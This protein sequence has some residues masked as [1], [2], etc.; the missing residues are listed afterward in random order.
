LSK[1]SSA[2]LIIDLKFYQKIVTFDVFSMNDVNIKISRYRGDIKKI[3]RDQTS[4][5]TVGKKDKL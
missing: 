3:T 1:G 2:E 5:E 4:W